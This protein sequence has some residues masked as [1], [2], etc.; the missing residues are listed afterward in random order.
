VNTANFLSAKQVQADKRA[1][2]A[3]MNSLIA[4]GKDNVN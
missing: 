2:A 4:E 1:R 3:E